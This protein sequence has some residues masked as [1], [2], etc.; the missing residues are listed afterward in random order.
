MPDAFSIKST[1]E[2]S[3]ALI[4]P[5]EIASELLLLNSST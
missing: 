5:S 4:E 3:S 1:D 2:C